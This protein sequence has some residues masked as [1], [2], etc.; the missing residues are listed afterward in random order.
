[1]SE[2]VAPESPGRRPVSLPRQLAAMVVNEVRGR[3]RDYSVLIYGIAVPLTL[4]TVLNV[5]LGPVSDPELSD[6]EVAIGAEAED[7]LAQGLTAALNGLSGLD[8]EV[9][10]RQVRFEEAAALAENHTVDL[11]VLIPA[12]VTTSSIHGTASQVEVVVGGGGLTS[13]VVVATVEAVVATVEAVVDRANAGARA[14]WAGAYAGLN[15][16]VLGTLAAGVATAPA[17]LEL[18]ADQAPDEQLDASGTLV[19]GQAGLFL[20][21]TVGF[22]VLSLLTER[23]QGTLARLHSM[24]MPRWSVIVAKATAGFALGVTSTAV[25]LTIGSLLFDVSLGSIPLIALMVVAASAAATS[26]TFIVARVVRTGEQANMVQSILAMVLGLAGGAFFPISASGFVATIMDL[27]PVA[28]F[29]RGIGIVAGGGGLTDLAAPL[30][31]LIGFA[32]ACTLI[33]RII[34]DR[35]VAS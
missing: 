16:S 7:P 2:L 4:M 34:P 33:S 17:Q 29:I 25:L 11:A 22:A 27:N 8:V 28:A 23:D 32:V 30:T 1:M 26:L 12:G 18:R 10:V 20:L 13:T 31:I 3:F 14:A 24:P 19:A 5:V 6:I 35:G 21:F 9:T 15:P